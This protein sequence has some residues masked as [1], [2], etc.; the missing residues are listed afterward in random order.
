MN[1]AFFTLLFLLSFATLYAQPTAKFPAPPGCVHIYDNVFI[2]QAEIANVHWVEYLFDLRL[3]RDV[4]RS[5]RPDTAVW[6]QEIKGGYFRNPQYQ[7]YPVVGVSFEQAKN[8][9]AWR[10]K[11]VTKIMNGREYEQYRTPGYYI[12]YHFRLPTEAEWEYAAAARLDSLD[13]DEY[14]YGYEDITGHLYDYGLNVDYGFPVKDSLNSFRN[15]REMAASYEP[16]MD[17]KRMRAIYKGVQ[18]DF[19][20]DI[21]ESIPNPLNTYQIVGNMAEMTAQ[22]GLAKGGSWQHPPEKAKVLERI[23]YERPTN[24]LGFRC[25]CEVKLKR[26]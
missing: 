22:E 26:P 5:Q 25:L 3:N 19:L 1:R 14:P 2:D 6:D 13:I 17:K 24:W 18:E 23:G 11:V 15:F 8:Y 7:Y 10:S 9:C 20:M 16:T 12:D 21:Y 4:Q